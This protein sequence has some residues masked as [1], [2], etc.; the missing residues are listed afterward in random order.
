[1]L[2]KNKPKY[3]N[4]DVVAGPKPTILLRKQLKLRRKGGAMRS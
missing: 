1:L 4:T 3:P 2:F